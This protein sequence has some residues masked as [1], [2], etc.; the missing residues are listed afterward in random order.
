MMLY[1][2]EAGLSYLDAQELSQ[3]GYI[4]TEWKGILLA[5]LLNQTKK[6]RIN[7]S[8][9]HGPKE[10]R[11]RRRVQKLLSFSHVFKPGNYFWLKIISVKVSALFFEPI[12]A[13]R[14]VIYEKKINSNSLVMEVQKM[15]YLA[16]MSLSILS[17]LNK[18]HIYTEKNC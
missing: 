16:L 4:S 5:L 9:E 8:E 3:L 6:K 10:P 18:M 14:E 12:E 11:A 13:F 15:E 7:H 17:K 2:F 1:T